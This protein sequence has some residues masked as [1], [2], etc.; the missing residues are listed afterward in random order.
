M[1]GCFLIIIIYIIN[2]QHNPVLVLSWFL[3][4]QVSI[5]HNLHTVQ[6]DI[7]LLRCPTSTEGPQMS[8]FF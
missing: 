6:V 7:E 3:K 2:N 5:V 8:K 4:R 1:V